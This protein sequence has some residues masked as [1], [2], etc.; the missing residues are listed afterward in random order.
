MHKHGTRTAKTQ[1]AFQHR[2]LRRAFSYFTGTRR[3]LAKAVYTDTTTTGYRSSVL[4]LHVCAVVACLLEVVGSSRRNVRTHCGRVADDRCCRYLFVAAA[5]VARAA[6]DTTRHSGRLQLTGL[7]LQRKLRDHVTK[8]D[9]RSLRNGDCRAK[10][11]THLTTNS[12]K[13]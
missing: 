2:T 8:S 7:L 9:P 3:Q 1:H 10:V 12:V 11:G 13:H 4:I 6:A 5:G